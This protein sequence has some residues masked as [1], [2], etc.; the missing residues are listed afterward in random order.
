MLSACELPS[1]SLQWIFC[2]IYIC[3]CWQVKW[4]CLGHSTCCSNS[5][6]ISLF[7]QSRVTF[8]AIQLSRC[9]LRAAS[10]FPAIHLRPYAAIYNEYNVAGL[11]SH[12]KVFVV[13]MRYIGPRLDME[14]EIFMPVIRRS[15][16]PNWNLQRFPSRWSEVARMIMKVRK[17]PI[18]DISMFVINIR[19]LQS[20]LSFE[21]RQKRS[22]SSLTSVRPLSF[23]L[24][25]IKKWELYKEVVATLCVDFT[26]QLWAKNQQHTTA[27]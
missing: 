27:Y 14:K 13:M 8:V 5:N 9:S 16:P 15:V 24:A 11:S 21:T 2:L 17:T 4:T 22:S 20:D 25:I 12:E 6:F 18:G 26:K 10:I 19:H 1:L 23:I 3:W 7:S